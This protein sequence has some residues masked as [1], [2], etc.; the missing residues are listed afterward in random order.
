ML[1]K[2]YARI[3]R[4][5]AVLTASPGQLVLMLYDGIL[6]ALAQTREAF[7]RPEHDIPRL[8]VINQQLLKAQAILSELQ[9][10]LNFEAGGEVA[11]NLD[12]VYDYYK[13]R[14]CEANLRKQ[15]AP[16]IEVEQLVGQLRG[17]WAEMLAKQ[18]GAVLPEP[19]EGV[20]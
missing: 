8:Q 7:R 16:V 4:S 12:R 10:G 9:G 3:Y 1:T 13:R 20:A 15:V 14:L 11:T 2:G 5:N 17:A 6:Q 19:V 18:T